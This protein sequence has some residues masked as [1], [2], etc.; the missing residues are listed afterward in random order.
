M[1]FRKTKK[2]VLILSLVFLFV[3]IFWNS[4]AVAGFF[5]D[6]AC[7]TGNVGSCTQIV[8]DIKTYTDALCKQK[9]GEREC[10]V[11]SKTSNEIIFDAFT[12]GGLT[13]LDPITDV[14]CKGADGSELSEL[15]ADVAGGKYKPTLEINIPGLNLSDVRSST[16]DTG[17]YFYIAWIPE[18]ISA[19]YKFGIAIVSIVAAVV[20]IIQGLRVV[21]SGG[22][23]G[24]TTAYKK[25][26]QSVIGLFIAWGSYAILYN[27]N[28]ALVEFNALKVKVVERVD[29]EASLGTTNV[30]TGEESGAPEPGSHPPTTI[31]CPFTLIETS[32]D[33]GRAE[34]YQKLQTS[35][36]VTATTP[37]EKTVQI[38]DIADACNINLGS[39]GRTAGA[40]VALA[41]TNPKNCLDPASGNCNGSYKRRI[42]AIS[43]NQRL[44]TY[45]W[46]CSIN[47][48]EYPNNPPRS[49]CVN[50]PLEATKII[51]DY[52][53]AQAAAGSPE[54]KGW[55]DEWANQLRPGDYVVFY[56]GNDDLVGSHAVIFMGWASEGRMQVVQGGMG[57][58]TNPPNST[59]SGTWCVKSSC[60]ESMVPLLYIYTPD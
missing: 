28:P 35:G 6:F 44:Y 42:R 32:G 30:A 29:L 7:L 52:L 57:K 39:C 36:A 53:K 5:D 1:F 47:K 15:Q 22:G 46:R 19:L 14:E 58:Y 11:T 40:I 34:F 9:C 3:P 49:N 10:E 18:L 38:A 43:Q 45:G 2:I 13:A 51:R 8:E 23:E 56:N 33:K 31:P 48:K 4:R 24:K 12:K 20:I 16:D 25:I 55:P 21:T 60:G 41:G 59:A 17:T 37:R 26:F 27:I 54:L 50:T